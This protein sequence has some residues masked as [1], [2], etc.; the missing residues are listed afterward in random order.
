MIAFSAEILHS[1]SQVLVS[2]NPH[3]NSCA[4]QSP[5]LARASVG[6]FSPT[7][8][9]KAFGLWLE[10][11]RSSQTRYWDPRLLRSPKQI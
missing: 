8:G 11:Y 9:V 4:V 2:L 1:L 5:G 7:F 6:T 3:V 10:G